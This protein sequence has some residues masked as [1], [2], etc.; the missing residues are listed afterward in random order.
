MID[1]TTT[2]TLTAHMHPPTI[3]IAM[4]FGLAPACALLAGHGMADSTARS[5]LSI[6]SFTAIIA[7]VVYVILDL[8]SHL[9]GYSRS[10]PLTG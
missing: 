5:W 7:V 9:W 4:L 6:V 8:E 10:R 3:I 1:I 2:R